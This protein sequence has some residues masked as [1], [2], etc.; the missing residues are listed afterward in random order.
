MKVRPWSGFSMFQRQGGQGAARTTSDAQYTKGLLSTV[1]ARS[2]T[3]ELQ[4]VTKATSSTAQHKQ[5]SQRAK[6]EVKPRSVFPPTTRKS[7][8]CV[9]VLLKQGVALGKVELASYKRY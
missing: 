1:C 6:H 7:L 5:R 4:S 9:A 8:Y 3:E 2:G